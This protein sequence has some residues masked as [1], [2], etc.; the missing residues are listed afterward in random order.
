MKRPS[1]SV[2]I[3]VYNAEKTIRKTLESI[4][5]QTFSDFEVIMIDDGS[6]DQC[7]EICDEYAILDRRFKVKHKKNEGVS[8]ARQ[9]GIDM[10]IGEYTIHV[11]P[12]DWIENSMLKELYEKA[13]EVNADMVI[14]DFYENIGNLQIYHKQQPSSLDSNTVLKEL[15]QQLHG[16]C[17]NKLV[18][19]VCYNNLDISFPLNMYFCEDLYV[20]AK[21]LMHP[22][23]VAYLPK[24]YYH[25]VQYNNKA[26]LVRYYDENTYNHDLKLKALFLELLRDSNAIHEEQIIEFF[27]KTIIFRA[28]ENGYNYYSSKLF[29]SRFSAF[30]PLVQKNFYGKEKFFLVLSING[31]Y[32]QARYIKMVLQKVKGYIRNNN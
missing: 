26:T 29:K 13:K 18:K 25:Y 23:N 4:R 1:I 32:R 17:C 22:I 3:P 14:C 7:G 20:N 10:A 27:D 30:L 8:A 12:D 24:A 9:T 28:F 5:K 31:F 6:I 19:R 21:I 15:F 11:D 2:I 16:S